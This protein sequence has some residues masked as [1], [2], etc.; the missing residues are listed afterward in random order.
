M[1]E[2]KKNKVKILFHNVQWFAADQEQ[3]ELTLKALYYRHDYM[4]L[5]Q[6]GYFMNHWKSCLAL[7]VTSNNQTTAIYAPLQGDSEQ[8]RGC[9]VTTVV[10]AKIAVC[11][12]F[13]YFDQVKQPKG[14]WQIVVCNSFL[15]PK[16]SF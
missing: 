13:N 9:L 14:V 16:S 1:L 11:E 5:K 2:P 10:W 3:I 15:A 8:H 4:E 7:I 6:N 12:D